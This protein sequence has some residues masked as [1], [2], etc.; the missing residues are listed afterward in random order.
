[1][2]RN[3]PSSGAGAVVA[4][5]NGAKS[6]EA[7]AAERL[8]ATASAGLKEREIIDRG[9]AT[10]VDLATE[11]DYSDVVPVLKNGECCA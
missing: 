4:A 5:L 11:F 3:S 6:P 2:P 1:M 8:F 10:D 7:I 9:F